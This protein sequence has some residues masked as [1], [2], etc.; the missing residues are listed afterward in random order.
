MMI[1]SSRQAARI[2]VA[3][4]LIS[5]SISS[6]ADVSIGAPPP[7]QIGVQGKTPVRVSDASGKVRIVTF[8]ASWCPPCRRE[9]PVLAQIQAQV[10]TDH[11]QVYA[12]NYKESPNTYRTL[13]K[14]L[15]GLS[16]MRFLHDTDGR[17]G[18]AY[19]VNGLP[20]MVII[21]RDGNVAHIHRGYADSV[22]DTVINE[23]NALLAS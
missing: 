15:D 18:A 3:A 20:L 22:I 4:V 21:D 2:L 17:V 9:L 11:L 5:A 13:M 19:G 6:A 10:G 14:K 16:E 12:I 7:D 1:E 23:L 8:W